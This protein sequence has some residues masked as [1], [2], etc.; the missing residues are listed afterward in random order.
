MREQASI[1][2]EGFF[3]DLTFWIVPL[4]LSFRFE[5]FFSNQ[6]CTPCIKENIHI[7]ILKYQCLSVYMYV[8]ENNAHSLKS[9][10]S[11]LPHRFLVVGVCPGSSN[12]LFRNS[13]LFQ[14][15]SSKKGKVEQLLPEKRA[16]QTSFKLMLI[17]LEWSIEVLMMQAYCFWPQCSELCFL[18]QYC[19][20]STVQNES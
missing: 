12:H 19:T 3:S 5:T 10:L 17:P 15:S 9:K 11:L 16:L 8:C 2:F 4:C 14:V 13:C 1:I 7:C 6:Q 20:T 18:S